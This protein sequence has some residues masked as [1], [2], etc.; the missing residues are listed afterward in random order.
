MIPEFVLTLQRWW[1]LMANSTKSFVHY[2]HSSMSNEETF[3][4]DFRVI[5][6]QMIQNY[7]K[8]LEEMSPLYYIHSDIYAQQKSSTQQ[9]VNKRGRVKL[10]SQYE[11]DLT[12]LPR[13]YVL[14]FLIDKSQETLSKLQGQKNSSDYRKKRS[15]INNKE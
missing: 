1:V 11:S 4:Q 10:Y 9:C 14:W 8:K 2:S 3:L 6:K 7:Q 5:L 12:R 13:K 15:K